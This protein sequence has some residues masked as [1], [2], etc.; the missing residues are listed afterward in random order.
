MD[1]T[2]QATAVDQKRA[3]SIGI[4]LI[5]CGALGSATAL[6]L[7]KMGCENLTFFDDDLVEEHNLPNQYYFPSSVGK[8]KVTALAEVFGHYGLKLANAIPEKYDGRP[9][10]LIISAVDSMSSR[11]KI[12]A[13]MDKKNVPIYIDSRMGLETLIVRTVSPNGDKKLRM[14][15]GGSITSDDD[16]VQEPCTA[17]SISYTPMLCGAVIGS[18]VKKVV[19]GEELPRCVMSDLVGYTTI[20]QE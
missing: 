7:G 18:M 11:R 12:W 15:Y 5:G 14:K 20:S 19:N 10:E 9:A 13:D 2:R 4:I 6:A 17:R 8:P 16:A 1:F 3:A